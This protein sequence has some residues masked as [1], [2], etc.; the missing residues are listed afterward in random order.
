M[1]FLYF[2]ELAITEMKNDRVRLGV[3]VLLNE[4]I[5][6]IAGQ[7]V[8]LV[9]NQASVMPDTFVHAADVFARTRA[10]SS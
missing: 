4:K 9:C 3:E 10:S 1:G 6:V 5:G 8:G 2:V 7:R